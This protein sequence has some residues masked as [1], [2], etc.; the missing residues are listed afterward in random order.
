MHSNIK[1]CMATG[2]HNN[3]LL[4]VHKLEWSNKALHYGL[5]KINSYVL[6]P[7]MKCYDKL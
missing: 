2:V 6:L 3:G 5:V 7:K 4:D 1:Y